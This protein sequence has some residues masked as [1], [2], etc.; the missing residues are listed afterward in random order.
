MAL[1]FVIVPKNIQRMEDIRTGIPIYLI[2]KKYEKMATGKNCVI[3]SAFRLTP[4]EFVDDAS[5][6]LG[7]SP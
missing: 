5:P 4:N 3:P 2:E 1:D 6:I 7:R